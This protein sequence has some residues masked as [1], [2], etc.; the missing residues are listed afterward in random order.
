MAKISNEPW[1]YPWRSRLHLVVGYM[2]PYPDLNDPE[3]NRK[4]VLI[5]DPK[6]GMYLRSPG[7]LGPSGRGL[8]LFWDIYG[9]DFRWLWRARRAIRL[10][11]APPGTTLSHPDQ[12][13]S[14]G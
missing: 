9:D 6:T 14:D 7:L 13:S 1:D 12:G 4:R 2:P 8:G 3:S 5:K 11:P 10:A